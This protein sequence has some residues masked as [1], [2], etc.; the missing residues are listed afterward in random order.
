MEKN[1][2]ARARI[3]Y[4]GATALIL[5]A[6]LATRVKAESLP[7]LV[8]VHFGD[9]LWAAMIYCGFRVIW[10]FKRAERALI[11]SLVFCLAIELSQLYHAE[12]IDSIRETAFGGLVLGRGFLSADFIRYGL[13]IG[14][15]YLLDR[16]FRA[17]TSLAS[18]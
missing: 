1:L 17:G 14:G 2:Q 12:W 9:A 3:A 16:F 5:V 8:S 13:G 15:I 11:A 18:S 7:D 10:T 6:G 4:I